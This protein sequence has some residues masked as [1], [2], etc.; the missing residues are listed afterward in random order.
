MGQDLVA[1]LCDERGASAGVGR[2]EA[3][4]RRST[5]ASTRGIPDASAASA[6]S[7]SAAGYFRLS[8]SLPMVASLGSRSSTAW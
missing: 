3:A 4:P 5:M 6:E 1:Q 7:R 8:R 2:T